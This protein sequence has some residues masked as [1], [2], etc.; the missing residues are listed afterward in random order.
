MDTVVVHLQIS[1][2]T[3]MVPLPK[4]FV[5]SLLEI[6]SEKNQVAFKDFGSCGF[7]NCSTLDG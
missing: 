1:G 3:R 7:V 6:S 2:F 5:Q 4:S